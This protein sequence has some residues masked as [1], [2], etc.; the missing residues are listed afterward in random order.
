MKGTGA[1]LWV[2][3]AIVVITSLAVGVGAA[4]ASKKSVKRGHVLLT[5]SG[6]GKGTYS[7]S[8]PEDDVGQAPGTCTAPSSSYSADDNYT[9]KWSEKF[10][11][12]EGIGSYVLARDYNVTGTDVT[13]QMQGTCT[14]G[15][16]SPVGGNSYSCTQGWNPFQEGTDYPAMSV[17]GPASR[18]RA[19]TI[20]GVQQ[21]GTPQGPTAS[22]RVSAGHL[23]ASSSVSRG[24]STSRPHS[25]SARARS[26]RR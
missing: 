4:S 20:G 18:L 3:C 14:N 7:W 19:T 9:F 26:P 23:T 22:A 1:R 13:T 5:F 6:T 16:G 25:Y 21:S 24:R 2:C 10:S 8:E 15:F 17:S 12:P 11:F